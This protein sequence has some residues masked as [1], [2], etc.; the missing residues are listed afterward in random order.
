VILVHGTYGHGFWRSLFWGFLPSNRRPKDSNWPIRKTLEESGTRVHSFTWSGQNSHRCRIKAGKELADFIVE[1]GKNQSHPISIS[2]VG[3]SHGG[4]VAL[5]ALKHPGT[6]KVDSIVCLATPFLHM[7]IEDLDLVVLRFLPLVIASIVSGIAFLAIL[8]L[9]V[10]VV[11]IYVYIPPVLFLLLW[12]IIGGLVW[13]AIYRM[14]H[15]KLSRLQEFFK[16]LPELCEFYQPAK[17]TRQRVLILRKIGDEATA[18]LVTGRL[19]EWLLTCAWKAISYPVRVGDTVKKSADDFREKYLAVHPN[20]KLILHNFR[21][22]FLISGLAVF[23]LIVLDRDMRLYLR[24]YINYAVEPV[25]YLLFAFVVTMALLAVA[26]LFLILIIVVL[27]LF[28]FGFMADL[29]PTF[30]IRINAEPTPLDSWELELFPAKGF[31]H[32]E[33]HEDPVVASRAARWLLAEDHAPSGRSH[34]G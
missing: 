1:L 34:D 11:P 10:V 28:R 8:Y 27:N 23:L 25:L 9:S 19:V 18:F 12:A 21:V 3:H 13:G 17:P 26:Q 7:S 5:Y 29:G 4:N 33:I 15:R 32:G 24:P 6:E 2:I 30:F 16:R 20:I 14:A 31:A 22:G